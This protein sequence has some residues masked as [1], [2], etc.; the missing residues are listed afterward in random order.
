M[1]LDW[2]FSR[3]FEVDET[4]LAMPRVLLNCHGLDT[5]AHVSIN[6]LPVGDA[7]NMHITWCWDVK[8][9]L[10]PGE[11]SITIAFDSPLNY[12]LA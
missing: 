5:L 12:A 2:D 8:P 9:F 3:C 10:H 1:Y 11:N 4:L 7:S 6:G